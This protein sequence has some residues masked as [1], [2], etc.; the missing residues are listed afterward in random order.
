[1]KKVLSLLLAIS[2]TLLSVSCAAPAPSAAQ[3]T[4]APAATEKPKGET[5]PAK[6]FDENGGADAYANAGDNPS[7]RYYV[8]PDFYHMKSDD[9]LTL[10][11]GFKTMQQTYEWSCGDA[12]AL[13]VLFWQ[14]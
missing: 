13:M 5:I 9:E 3:S 6:D 1:M 8:N 7:S 12:T 11:E 10:I 14:D 2:F 4:A